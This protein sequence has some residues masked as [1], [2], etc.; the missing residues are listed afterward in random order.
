MV[1]KYTL[2]T[3]GADITAAIFT[4]ETVRVTE[5]GGR[6]PS[7]ESMLTAVLISCCTTSACIQWIESFTPLYMM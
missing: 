2:N 5:A 7:T 3:C 1:Y 4:Q 6:V